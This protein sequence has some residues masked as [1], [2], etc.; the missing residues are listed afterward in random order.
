MLGFSIL[1]AGSFSLGSL[2]ANEISP[3]ALNAAR[4][5]L[6]AAATGAM[7]TAARSLKRRHFR[8]PWRHALPG[9]VFAIYFTLMFEGLKTASPLSAAALFTLLPFMA[10]GFG[11]L[12]LR[13]ATTP[14][15]AAALSTGAGGALWV[16]FEGSPAALIAL[17]LGR[18]EAVYL[19]G[20]VAHAMYIPLAAKLARGEPA[21]AF[22]FGVTVSCAILLLAAGWADVASTPWRDLPPLVWAII[23]YL[24]FFASALALWAMQYAAARLPAAKVMAY[25]YLTPSWVILWEIALG[26]GLPAPITLAGVAMTVAALVLLFREGGRQ[27][28]GA[29][30][31]PGARPEG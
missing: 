27:S 19:A 31:N 7:A 4:F 25:S 29:E 8:S 11:Y 15:A 21:I 22:A 1:V 5:M 13:Q 26:N 3:V 30:P 24:A 6:A 14:L 2:V 9:A 20:C 28:R 10:A 23:L 18:G 12:L 16:V 17:D